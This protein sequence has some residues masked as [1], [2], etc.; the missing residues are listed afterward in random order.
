MRIFFLFMHNTPDS[1]DSLCSLAYL[2][3]L[4]FAVI[5]PLLYVIWSVDRKKEGKKREKVY[6]NTTNAVSYYVNEKYYIL[7][8]S[9]APEQQ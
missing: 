1:T 8:P 6:I 2:C 4:T 9:S 5:F 3:L 7:S